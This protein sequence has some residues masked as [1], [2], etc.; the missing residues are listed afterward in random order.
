MAF[1]F[2]LTFLL[3]SALFCFSF[4]RNNEPVPSPSSF[5]QLLVEII[6][7]NDEKAYIQAFSL[8]K[9]EWSGYYNQAKQNPYLSE[10]EKSR[11]TLKKLDYV[12]GS[13]NA[14]LKYNFKKI[15]LWIISD[16]IDV[17]K[18]E[19]LS[20]DYKLKF[21]K[22]ENPAYELIESYT[23]IKYEDQLYRI[24]F[25]NVKYINNR[26]VYGII[27]EIEKVDIYLNQIKP[28]R[29]YPNVDDTDSLIVYPISNHKKL[30][31][32][33]SLKVL[34]LQRKINAIYKK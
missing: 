6:K 19:Y 16:S 20:A 26:W 12:I 27:S 3:S 11:I 30:S 8:S 24:R 13:W 4:I 17:H 23:L 32:H 15:K 18:I 33:D 9:D 31:Q 10:D 34:N 7:H 21:D 29:F 25:F 28:T 2:T 14:D 5:G 1:K 22:K